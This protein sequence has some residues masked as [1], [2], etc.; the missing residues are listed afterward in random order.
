MR[1]NFRL[2]SHRSIIRKVYRNHAII[3]NFNYSLI[4][5]LA[6]KSLEEKENFF[7]CFISRGNNVKNESIESDS[8]IESKK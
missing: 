2:L 4:L 1:G 8:K 3:I 5:K 6:I 7:N